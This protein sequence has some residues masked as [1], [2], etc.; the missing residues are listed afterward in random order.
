MMRRTKR[1]MQLV[2]EKDFVGEQIREFRSK[3]KSGSVLML[4]NTDHNAFLRDPEQ[5]SVV[6]PAMRQF[7]ASQ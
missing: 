2:Y 4:R 7:L 3:M 1:S 5:L 6:V